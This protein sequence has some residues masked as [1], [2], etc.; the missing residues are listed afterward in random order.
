MQS[1]FTFFEI[2]KIKRNNMRYSSLNENRFVFA[3]TA[4]AYTHTHTYIY[5]YI[6][7]SD[8]FRLI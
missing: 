2:E 1:Y 6:S 3:M 8:N 5:I 4:V 7:L